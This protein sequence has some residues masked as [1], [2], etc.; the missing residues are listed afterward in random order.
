VICE[1]NDPSLS[2]CHFSAVSYC[3][4][5]A[6]GH[7]SWFLVWCED[8]RCESWNACFDKKYSSSCEVETKLA[9]FNPRSRYQA[10]IKEAV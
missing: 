2:I 1:F 9:W 7:K 3:G 8:D 10:K 4:Q 6:F 5:Q